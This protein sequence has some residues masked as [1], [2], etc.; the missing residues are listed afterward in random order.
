MTL[1]DTLKKHLEVAKGN[2]LEL[3]SEV[4]WSHKTTENMATKQTPSALAYGYEERLPVELVP[5]ISLTSVSGACLEW[6]RATSLFLEK[7]IEGLSHVN[8]NVPSNNLDGLALLAG[9]LQE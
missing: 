6:T 9:R 7:Y 3:L 4:L 1:K 5:P 2:C 8:R